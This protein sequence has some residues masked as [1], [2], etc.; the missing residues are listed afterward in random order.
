MK[1]SIPIALALVFAVAAFADEV[2]QT[3][4]DKVVHLWSPRR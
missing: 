1:R 3:D 2:P 4:S